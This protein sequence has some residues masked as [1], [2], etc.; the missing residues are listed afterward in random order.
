MR[1]LIE[2][3]VLF[4]TISELNMPLSADTLFGDLKHRS[5]ANKTDRSDNTFCSPFL[6]RVYL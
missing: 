4:A 3:L 1:Y 2:S 5:L 6:L